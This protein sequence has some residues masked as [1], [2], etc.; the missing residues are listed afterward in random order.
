MTTPGNSSFER[1]T[2]NV[3]EGT[4]MFFFFLSWLVFTFCLGIWAN[5][6]GRSGLGWAILSF[7]ISPLL[8]GVILLAIGRRGQI[9]PKCAEMVKVDAKVCRFCGVDLAKP[10]WP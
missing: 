5:R 7:F 10:G 8:S 1:S 6:W 9:C 3:I 2:D 4:T